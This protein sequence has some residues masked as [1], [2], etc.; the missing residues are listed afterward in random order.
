MKLLLGLLALVGGA[1]WLL[2]TEG[3]TV[4]RN[5]PLKAPPRNPSPLGSSTPDKKAPSSQSKAATAVTAPGETRGKSPSKAAPS[6]PFAENKSAIHTPTAGYLD[7]ILSELDEKSHGLERHNYLSQVVEQAYKERAN[8]ST[9]KILEYMAEFHIKE[10]PK[11]RPTLKNANNGAL[12]RVPT[13]QK[14]AIFL[15]EKGEYQRAIE[16]CQA[17]IGHGLSDGTKGDF[18]ERIKRIRKKQASS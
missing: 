14:Y 16:V 12:P 11:I 1:A 15:T 6:R 18:S 5:N 2:R 13:F 17:A 4:A 7:Q 9:A 10:F 3:S 8:K